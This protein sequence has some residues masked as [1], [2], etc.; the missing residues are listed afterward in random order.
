MRPLTSNLLP[1]V[2]ALFLSPFFLA[3]PLHAE[4]ASEVCHIADS[5]L[6]QASKIRKLPIKKPVPC[7]VHNKDQVAKY[8]KDTIATKLPAEK[9]DMEEYVYKAL[10]F[11]PAAFDYKKGILDLYLSQ[12]G[13]YYDPD[14]KH[15]IMAAW[16]PEIMQTTI[17][18]HEMTHALQD[19]YFNLQGFVDANIENSDLLMSRSALVEGDATAVMLDYARL[20]AGQ[21]PLAQEK[22]VN[23]FIMQNVLGIA[24]MANASGVP[25]SMQSLLVFPYTSGLRFAHVLLQKGGYP[26][27]D[28]AFKK[29]PRSTEE[30]LHPEK[31]FT[32]KADYKE[33]S[34]A[35]FAAEQRATGN[36]VVYR[37]TLGEFAISA[38]LGMYATDKSTAAQAAAGWGGDRVVV[39]RSADKS[40]RTIVWKIAWD[41]ERDRDEFVTLFKDSLKTIYPHSED[42]KPLKMSNDSKI[43]TLSIDGRVVTIVVND[44]A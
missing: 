31:Y 24:M 39:L 1:S 9:L 12:L 14:R 30:V 38:L 4:S 43:L 27:I 32:D 7:R 11:L 42:G 28:K 29:V 22:D 8:L 3:P 15:F 23:S 40:K 25:Q 33:F 2:L 37:D 36:P 21:P 17:A 26:E 10:G 44:K 20:L 35:D 18:V 5:S 6:E 34:D 19:Q 16:L 41:T 13:G